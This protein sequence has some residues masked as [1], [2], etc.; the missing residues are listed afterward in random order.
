MFVIASSGSMR[1]EPMAA[2][3]KSV[4]DIASWLTHQEDSLSLWTFNNKVLNKL[5]PMGVKK[6]DM[7]R[8][9]ADVEN[10]VKYTTRLNDALYTVSKAW[11]AS[12]MPKTATFMVFLTDGGENNSNFKQYQVQKEL[13]SMAETFDKL[14][15][16]TA[17]SSANEVAYLKSLYQ[18]VRDK[19]K[20]VIK[21]VDSNR[22]QNIE[23]LFGF[24]KQVIEEVIEVKY[25]HKGKMVGSSKFMGRGGGQQAKLAQAAVNDINTKMK[26]LNFAIKFQ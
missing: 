9:Q 6:V 25:Y 5:K 3:M 16:L 13:A 11:D 24:A 26:Q 20:C 19:Q 7:R 2:V 15:F 21:S 22:A 10:H 18:S 17:G 8:L 1:G 4:K 23:S 14:I 12:K